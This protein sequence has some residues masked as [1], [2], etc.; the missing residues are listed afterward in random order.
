VTSKIHEASPLFAALKR[1]R[2][3]ALDVDGVLT[4]GGMH[5]SQE[6][7]L[8]KR[9][10]IQDG[11]GLVLVPSLGVTVAIITGR[12]SQIVRQRMNDLK[13][14]E[15][16]Q[17]VKRKSEVLT[18]IAERYGLTLDEILYMG[19]DLPDLKALSLAG[20]SVAPSDAHQEA[21]AIASW[22]TEARGGHG[23]VREVCDALAKAKG[24]Y[25][26]WVEAFVNHDALE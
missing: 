26:A 16:H 8:Y 4:D 20:V 7:E 10:S 18:S 14:H 22:V 11:L 1:I 2:L 21:K 24:Q 9:F 19:D 15:V 13:I 6:G 17:G 5:F 23:A 25:D 3:M 12:S